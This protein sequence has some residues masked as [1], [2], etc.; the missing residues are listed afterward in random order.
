M[1]WKKTL[2]QKYIFRLA[3]RPNLNQNF[4]DTLLLMKIQ[5]YLFVE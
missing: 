1:Q 3:I 5:D 4:L 2:C